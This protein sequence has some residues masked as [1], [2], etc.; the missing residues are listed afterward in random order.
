MASN[1]VLGKMYQ[2][3][4][5]VIPGTIADVLLLST[6]SLGLL[7]PREILGISAVLSSVDDV[8]ILFG[9]M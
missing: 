7:T 6:A 3:F 4:S 5:R 9:N 2:P 1:L 8:F